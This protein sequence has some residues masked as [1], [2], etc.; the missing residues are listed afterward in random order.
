MKTNGQADNDSFA[1]IVI[2]T[3][4]KKSFNKINT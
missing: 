3:T 2:S 1:H 4:A